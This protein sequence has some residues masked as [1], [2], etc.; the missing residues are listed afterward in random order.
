MHSAINSAFT[1]SEP[2]LAGLLLSI[3]TALSL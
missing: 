1:V 3:L 2:V